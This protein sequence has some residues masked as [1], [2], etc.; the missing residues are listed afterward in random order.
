MT[1]PLVLAVGEQIENARQAA[2]ERD[3]VQNIVNG[4]A[5]VAIIGTDEVGHVTLFNPGAERLLG[6]TAEEML[7]TT[8]RRLH[9]EESIA[10]KARELGVPERVRGGGRRR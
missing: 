2:A 5:S 1:L 9:S 8:T 7:G 3:K 10:E 6:Y 4:A